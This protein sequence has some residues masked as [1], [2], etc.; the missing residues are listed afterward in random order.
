MK[1]IVINILSYLKTLLWGVLLALAMQI[2]YGF[3]EGIINY[4]LSSLIKGEFILIF[5]GQLTAMLIF[6]LILLLILNKFYKDIQLELFC[7]PNIKWVI[8]SLLILTGYLLVKNNSLDLILCFLPENPLFTKA[9]DKISHSDLSQFI[10][11][12]CISGPIVEEIAVRGIVLN[13]LLKK[14]NDAGAII[15]SAL[16]FGIVHLDVQ[17]GINAFIVGCI[18]G[19]VYRHTRSIL[20]C[21]ILHILLNSYITLSYFYPHY[22]YQLNEWFD[23]R[24]LIIGAAF[25]TFGLAINKTLQTESF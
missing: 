16:V 3:L 22:I 25:L 15:L 19:Y 8:F 18:L 4:L 24:E 11:S 20:L 5:L 7:M 14:F 17:Q 10:F 21:I 1:R 23:M 12:V 2:L 13:R 9:M 6:G